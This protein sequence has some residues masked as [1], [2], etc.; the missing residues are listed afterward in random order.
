MTADQGNGCFEALAG[1]MVLLHCRA[2]WRAKQVR[3]V[4]IWATV[5]FTTWGLW[6]AA[7]YYPNL[8][9][10]WSFAGGL[11]VLAANVWWIVLMVKYR[12]RKV[13]DVCK[14]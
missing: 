9:Q 13:V 11:F 3:G 10:W 5:F 2:A 1:L 7:F 8:A 12:E 4:S 6:N 14:T